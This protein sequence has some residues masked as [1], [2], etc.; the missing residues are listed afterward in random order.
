MTSFEIVLIV[1]LVVYTVLLSYAVW[2]I[3]KLRN[4]NE[5]LRTNFVSEAQAY[6]QGVS[7]GITK[8]LSG[9]YFQ[10]ITDGVTLKRIAMIMDEDKPSN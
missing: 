8:S 4:E 1:A 6:Q 2:R 9:K 3:E 10:L 5:K 7:V